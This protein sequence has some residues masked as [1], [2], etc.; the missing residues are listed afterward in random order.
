MVADVGQ[1]LRSILRPLAVAVTFNAM[2][3][4]PILTPENL[5]P[6]QQTVWDGLVDSRGGS[7]TR[8]DGGLAG[9]FNAW[10]HA[11]KIGKAMSRLGGALRFSMST[12][13]RLIELA[14]ITVGAH[15][16]AEFEWWAHARMARDH[17]VSDSIIDA[18]GN[19]EEPELT[20][21]AD[22]ATYRIARE[23][24]T[25]G[26]L[27]DDTH[28]HAVDA[29]GHQSVVELV[30]LCGYYTLISFTLNAFEVELPEGE[31]E[32]WPR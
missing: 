24:V 17:G 18:I 8:P 2:T 21:P 9:P 19:D 27:S 28:R 20:D 22:L 31:P 3:R 5:S 10:L 26:R 15:W 29:L 32:K 13:R 7:V 25:G 6:E 14:I 1:I 30:S 12:D 23:L 16:Q 4:L 11:P